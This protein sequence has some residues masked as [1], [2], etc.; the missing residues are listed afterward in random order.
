MNPRHESNR[1]YWNALAPEWKG[2]P[3]VAN[4]AEC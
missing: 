1:D 4:W 3:V 2:D